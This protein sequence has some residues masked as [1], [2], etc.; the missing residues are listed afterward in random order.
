MFNYGK[1]IPVLIPVNLLQKP[2]EYAMTLLWLVSIAQFV[3]FA[4]K[5]DLEGTFSGTIDWYISAIAMMLA[6]LLIAVR[7]KS[8]LP[9][10]IIFLLGISA[11]MVFLNPELSE[12]Y[13]LFLVS[14][15]S[16]CFWL[17]WHYF[18]NSHYFLRLYKILVA[19]SHSEQW[20]NA[21]LSLCFFISFL[22]INSCVLLA[23]A[24]DS[25]YAFLIFSTAIVFLFVC[26]AFIGETLRGVLLPVYGSFI[27][28]FFFD[29]Y[30]TFF[31]W[32]FV[33]WGA[34][35]LF[36]PFYQQIFITKKI[37]TDL[38]PWYGL[39]VQLI[40]FFY[41]AP[42]SIFNLFNLSAMVLYLFLMFRNST[43]MSLTYA[44]IAGLF[45]MFVL[46]LNPKNII[47]SFLLGYYGQLLL[48]FSILL[49]F[50]DKVWGCCVNPSLRRVGWHRISFTQPVSV[51]SFL[52][53][54]L[55]LGI[56]SIT[57]FGLLTHWYNFL[58]VELLI[59]QTS[60][61]VLLVFMA[62]LFVN[63]SLQQ[64]KILVHLNHF[65]ALVLLILIWGDSQLFPSYLLFSLLFL[66]WQLLPL[67]LASSGKISDF[68]QCIIES[69]MYWVVI[70]FISA[71]ACLIYAVNQTDFQWDS[72]SLLITLL[73]L[74]S[75]SMVLVKKGMSDY[76]HV[77]AYALAVP[78]ILSLR[79]VLMG[80][81]AINEWDTIGLFIISL[82]Y[83]RVRH[84]KA[85]SSSFINA[86]LVAKLLP[87][88]ALVTIS[89]T[90]G[91]VH[92]SLTLFALAVF[93]LIIQEQGR[94]IQ[95]G[96]FLLLNSAAYLW[97]PIL[98]D[99]TGLFLF[100]SIPV[101]FSV[102][103]VSYLHRNEI[104]RG[105]LSSIR[106]I[107]LSLFYM[108]IAADIFIN[109]SL[110][111]FAIGLMIAMAG[112]VFGISSRI[113]AFLYTGIVFMV[114]II[115]G[116]LMMFYPEGRLARALILM[117][118]GA[119]ITASMIGF[120]MKREMLLSRIKLF[121]ADLEDWD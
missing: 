98:S 75:G 81:I 79:I 24:S 57:V 12:D 102:L 119:I 42:D 43:A 73:L 2:I 23:I 116:Q 90:M 47:E 87:L 110:M 67:M 59:I 48:C 20:I 77:M 35:N 71:L 82:N 62:L 88:S 121:R 17:F 105:L 68:T 84:Y 53:A 109:D 7:M 117:L 85:L 27:L 55:Y 34:H 69:A 61:C 95:Y 15:Y 112:I 26:E 115:I 44:F 65:S 51:M 66:V 1:I 104:T 5:H 99:T 93:Y 70:S 91:S 32:A 103:F 86:E 40:V 41:D 30:N 118:M 60:V 33:L 28:F 29:F 22:V 64:N 9:F 97:M 101:V 111:L 106:L 25:Y 3:N 54:L 72:I 96:A 58:Q 63:K 18:L 120:N 8:I 4:I 100:Y 113:R 45:F 11:V 92:S 108:L 37:K 38:W 74:F 13:G 114:L 56:S 94:M 19:D 78:L 52:I 39:L 89:W 10:P 14:V 76:W 50:A 31:I 49:L 83:Y 16:L 36:S 80:H 6:A 46:M 21:F 107:T